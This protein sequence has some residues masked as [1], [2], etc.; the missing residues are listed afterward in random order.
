MQQAHSRPCDKNQPISFTISITSGSKLSQDGGR[1]DNSHTGIPKVP[2][3]CRA[4][5]ILT[6]TRAWDN[7]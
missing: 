2:T 7:W 4:H 6:P 5:F 3:V 1:V